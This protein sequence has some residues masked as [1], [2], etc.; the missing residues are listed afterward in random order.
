MTSRIA[1]V[2]IAALIVL[3]IAGCTSTAPVPPTPDA[4][5]AA[6][7]PDEEEAFPLVPDAMEPDTLLV[8]RAVAT[9]ANGARLSLEYH[10]HQSVR[11]DD[12]AFATLPLGVVEDCSGTL[13]EAQ[14][15]TESW[16]F[17]RGNLTAI[18]TGDT[19]DWP[20]DARIDVVPSAATVY[21]AGRG[22]L[23]AEVDTVPSCIASKSFVGS[24]RGALALGIPGDAAGFTAWAG[25]RFGFATTSGVTFSDCAVELTDLGASL[26]GG[27]G[28]VAVDEATDCS[29]GPAIESQDY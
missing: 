12:M 2:A 3:A 10:V 7:V 27:A 8:V 5:V 28:W 6:A 21:T 19:A 17:T 14:F 15:S 16:S 23:A 9:A 1:P 18:P 29:T 4:T 13:T 20:V 25:H 26:G 11:F 24:G 22:M